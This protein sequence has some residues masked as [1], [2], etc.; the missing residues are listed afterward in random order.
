MHHIARTLEV[1]YKSNLMFDETLI[2]LGIGHAVQ[3]FSTQT[4]TMY[5]LELLKSHGHKTESLTTNIMSK[6]GG[7]IIWKFTL[8]I[9]LPEMKRYVMAL[10]QGSF[11]LQ[12]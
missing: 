5:R 7:Q 8:S 10:K 2:K 6:K 12:L 4:T 3:F 9:T 1:S 11:L